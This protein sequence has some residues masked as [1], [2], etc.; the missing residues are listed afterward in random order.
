[1][2]HGSQEVDVEDPARLVRRAVSENEVIHAL[3]EV[4]E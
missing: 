1:M 2:T 3:R 4:I